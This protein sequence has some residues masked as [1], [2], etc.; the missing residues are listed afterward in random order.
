MDIKID[1]TEDA[2][3]YLEYNTIDGVLDFYFMAGASPIDVARQYSEV[4]SKAAMIPYWGF[5]F[6]NCRFGYSSVMMLP[7]RCVISRLRISCF[8][9]CGLTL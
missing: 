1:N 7:R 2:G 5:G 6:H 9:L 3:Q 8:R 4:T